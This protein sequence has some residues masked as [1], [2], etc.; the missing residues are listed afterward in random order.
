[1]DEFRP[2]P[3][4]YPNPDLPYSLLAVAD[5]E[6]V[7]EAPAADDW[8]ELRRLARGPKIEIWLNVIPPGSP[9]VQ[10]ADMIADQLWKP[11]FEAFTADAQLP[12][13][14]I[15]LNGSQGFV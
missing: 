14:E 6:V 5:R 9:A 12:A 15:R 8:N 10:G 2:E 3:G 4:R 13:D 11:M 7:E 1:M